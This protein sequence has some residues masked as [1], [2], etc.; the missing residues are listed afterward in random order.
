MAE[1]SIE[2]TVILWDCSRSMVRADFKPS[3]L[4]ILQKACQI[5]IET[6]LQIDPKDTIAIA[7]YGS[8]TKKIADFSYDSNFLI[9]QTKQFE[10]AGNSHLEDG[11]A[12]SLQLLVKQ[13]QKLGGKVPRII[14]F[15]DSTPVN[16]SERIKKLAKLAQGLG[17]FIDVC[18]IG[19]SK[20]SEN[21]LKNL[22]YSTNAEY[23]FFNNQ[24]ALFRA[25]E[26][27]AS[28]KIVKE[29][30]D[31][32]NPNKKDKIP[33]LISEISVN[34][35]R[36]S[37]NEIRDMMHGK[38]DYKCQICYQNKCPTCHANFYTCG[39]FCPSCGRPLHLHC[40]SMWAQKA[41]EGNKNTFRC[42]FCYFLLKI[43]KS[44]QK[45]LIAS[46]GSGIKIL[47]EDISSGPI[48]MIFI[49]DNQINSI[50]DACSYCNNIFLEGEQRVYR[51]SGEDCRSYYHESCLQKMYN[52]IKSC[53]SCGGQIQK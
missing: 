48:K 17:V 3:R 46:G 10:I 44:V 40:S 8:R 35:R 36:P 49:P 51:C 27:F 30:E 45:L 16:P 20:T 43:P 4:R 25:A 12:F 52:E 9:E 33:I 19:T 14:V 5:F 13:I 41:S 1:I 29:T 31:Y 26:G 24:K 42:P 37:I 18:Q 28:K 32:F 34:L 6:K 38:T 39:R 53:R 23:A 22:A 15:T 11:I 2:D 50:E 47:D 21:T 7:T